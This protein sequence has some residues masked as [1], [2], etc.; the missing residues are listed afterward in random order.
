MHL[1]RV[2]IT[3]NPTLIWTPRTAASALEWEKV[4]WGLAKYVAICNFGGTTNAV[5]NSV[6]GTNWVSRNQPANLNFDALAYSPTLHRFVA[7]SKVTAALMTSD[8]D[9]DT[10]TARTGSA[11]KGWTYVCWSPDH[12]QFVGIANTDNGAGNQVQ[13][14][15]D[16]IT[17]TAQTHPENNTWNAVC[18]GIPTTGTVRYVAV[19]SAGTNRVMTSP[20]GVTW[21]AQSASSA[22]TWCGVTFGNGLFVAVSTTGLVMTSPDGVTWTARTAAASSAWRIVRF[23]GG[24][25]VAVA[26]GGT[27]AQRAMASPD[28]INW[29]LSVTPNPGADWQGLAYGTPSGIGTWVA[30]GAT[31]NPRVMTTVPSAPLTAILPGYR[32]N[33]DASQIVGLASNDPVDT[34]ADLS[35]N[36]FDASAT[37]TERP[38]YKTAYQGSK[39]A[40]LFDGINDNL[41]SP[42]ILFPTGNQHTIYAVLSHLATPPNWSDA[43]TYMDSGVSAGR[44]TFHA[45][46][47]NPH[48]PGDP[49]PAGV[50]DS[51]SNIYFFRDP[52]EQKQLPISANESIVFAGRLDGAN[53]KN[54][55]NGDPART[56]TYSG[57]TD[58]TAGAASF[59]LGSNYNNT[60]QYGAVAWCHFIVYPVAHTDVEMAL[61]SAFLRDF[62]EI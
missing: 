60:G 49:G 25:F 46:S 56:V 5:M 16:G 21:T 37:L 4:E 41:E 30:V 47:A 19:A 62:W 12:N 54:I 38:L 6:D 17:W 26:V 53:S 29:T 39:P 10:W 3:P 59:R 15:P 18:Y 61:M 35:A 27:T 42:H 43:D 28:G 48:W 23:G 58:T 32:V 2:S 36:A 13:T 22:A 11:V 55:I 33:F 31:S 7:L 20:D 40:V 52:D 1:P 24:L 34:W 9:G 8:D 14:S 51:G 57:A 45:V 44:R 50:P